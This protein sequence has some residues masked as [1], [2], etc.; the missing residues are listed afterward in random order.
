MTQ[1]VHCTERLFLLHFGMG[2]PLTEHKIYDRSIPQISLRIDFH[3][4]LERECRRQ[5]KF[6]FQHFH[7]ILH[8]LDISYLCC[9]IPA[10]I[11]NVTDELYNL[12]TNNNK[13]IKQVYHHNTGWKSRQIQR[14]RQDEPKS[15]KV[16][17]QIWD[18]AGQERYRAITN[19]YYR[20]ANGVILVY[21]VTTHSRFIDRK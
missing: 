12:K 16:R 10:K 2:G 15:L 5:R 20:R 8:K 9:K 21:D 11:T 4:Q 3:R 18:T 14:Q 19:L 13:R 6:L 7:R 17:T 1:H